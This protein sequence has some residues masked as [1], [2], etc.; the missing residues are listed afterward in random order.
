M[1]LSL[2]LNLDRQFIIRFMHVELD[3]RRSKSAVTVPLTCDCI[4][5]IRRGR[6]NYRIPTHPLSRHYNHYHVHV[7]DLSVTG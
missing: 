2:N 7:M 5:R 4:L 3:L 6:M 1:N